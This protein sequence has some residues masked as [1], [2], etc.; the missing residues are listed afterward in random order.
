MAQLYNNLGSVSSETGDFK[1]A[2]E[3]YHRALENFEIIK[4]KAG[5]AQ[6][7]QNIGLIYAAKKDYNK[8][9]LYY[10][11]SLTLNRETDNKY[12]I[13]NIL[14]AIGNC[15]TEMKSYDK[16]IRYLKES[17]ELAI[18]TGLSNEIFRNCK[19]L[20][21]AYRGAKDYVKSFDYIEKYIQLKDSVYNAEKFKQLSELQTKYETEKKKKEIEI[22]TLKLKE[23]EEV[24]KRQKAVIY[25]IIGGLILISFFSILLYRLYLKIRKKNL[26]LVKQ[27][28][29]IEIQAKELEKLSI[30]ASET[31]NSVIIANAEGIIEYVNAGFTKLFEYTFDEFASMRGKNIVKTSFYPDFL[32]LFLDCIEKKN[33]VVYTTLSETKSGKKIWVQTTLTPYFDNNG[34]LQKLIAIDSDVTKIKEAEEEIRFQKKEITDSIHYAKRIQSAILP[35]NENLK[36]FIGDYFILFRPRDIVSGDFYWTTSVHISDGVTCD[37]VSD[38]MSGNRVSN[39]VFGSRVTSSHPVTIIA[40]ADC[41]GHGVPGAFMSMLGISFLNEIF[42]NEKIVN[43]A[44]ILN[45]LR[46]SVIESLKQ[47][48]A[49][50]EMKIVSSETL[51]NSSAVVSSYGSGKDTPSS[52]ITAVK[53]P[54]AAN[55]NDGSSSFATA[56]KDGMDIALC[57]LDPDKHILQFAGANNP[58]WIIRHDLQGS[59]NKDNRQSI[60]NGADQNDPQGHVNKGKSQSI[61]Y[62]A[63]QYDPTGRENELIEIKG[64]KMPIAIYDKMPPFVTIEI[65]VH[66][67]DTFYIFSDGYADQFGGPKG[68]K[69]MYKRMK[70]LL[71][72]NRNSSMPDQRLALEKNLTEW[73]SHLDPHSG[74]PYEQVDDICVIG[75][76]I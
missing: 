40:V 1:K 56:V 73:M 39:V 15:F 44:Q 14:S 59:V 58:L 7:L 63:D 43:P 13:V 49:S 22:K 26:L 65:P 75:L 5:K 68:K 23:S 17:Y 32:D 35:R 6:A 64:D 9:Q 76:R 4:D 19:S 8:A 18:N 10:Q 25:S 27:K 2:I 61:A 31:D 71:I 34:N 57:I 46:K 42:N 69:L 47:K 54:Y 53:T 41:T 28:M 67:G 21:E 20:S 37:R 60:A 29:E 24:N 45:E 48:G 33:S 70:Q 50:E 12:Q 62:S 51:T 52:F 11:Q 38:E 36:D 55:E 30:V 66:K 72:E 74:K 16:A 3:Y